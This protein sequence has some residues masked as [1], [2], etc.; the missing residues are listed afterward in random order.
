V[1]RSG[2][3]AKA[4]TRPARGAGPSRWGAG[5]RSA[6]LHRGQLLRLFFWLALAALPGLG[7]CSTPT[8]TQPYPGSC[9][10]FFGVV[11]TPSNGSINVPRDTIARVQ[12]NQYPDP[13]TVNL[14]GFIVTTGVFYHPGTM[15]LDLV[16]KAITYQPAGNWNPDLG[17]NIV[18]R[19]A[20]RSLQGCPVT[21]EQRSFRTTAAAPMPAPAPP[22]TTYA[23]IGPLF[24]TRCAGSGCHRATVAAGGGCSAAPAAG[25][26]LCDADV[27]AALLDVPSTQV[28]RLHLV[29]PRDSARS[30]ILRKL[31]PGDRPDEPA[32]TT[33]GHRCPPGA[34][35]SAD[36]IHAIARW[37]DAG[38]P[39]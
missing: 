14:S 31:L 26:S 32:P 23:Q 29:E 13:D 27:V 28:S 38:L 35:L 36:E 3:T 39:P 2:S 11:W 19:S 10:P 16:D 21:P 18:V 5:K 25:L 15:H 33:Q 34:P 30:Y 22:P 8:D 24:A 6:A 17:Y 4:E 1:S 7:A 12:F 20:L 37:I 9:D